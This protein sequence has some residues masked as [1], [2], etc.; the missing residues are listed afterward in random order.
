MIHFFTKIGGDV[1]GFE[2]T[3]ELEK[4]PPLSYRI[5]SCSIPFA[6]RSRIMFLLAWYPKLVYQFTLLAIRSMI[7]SKPLPSVVVLESDVEVLVFSVVRT[8]ISRN[9]R[10]HI[11][12]LSFI[13][14]SRSSRLL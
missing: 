2:F 9:R 11:V 8:F 6:Y 5:F 12:Y 4:L 14:T 1:R 13:Y 7:S 3:K 10:P